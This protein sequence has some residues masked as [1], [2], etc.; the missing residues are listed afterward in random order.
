MPHCEIYISDKPFNFDVSKY[1]PLPRAAGLFI[2]GTD[3]DIGKTLVAG[4]IARSLRRGG[5]TVEVYKPAASGCRHAR[6]GLISSDA[7]FLAACADSRRTLTE[8]TPIRYASPVA[9]NVAAELEGRP[10]DLDAIFD[11]YRKLTES[12]N[13][14]IVEGVGGLLCPISDNFWVIHLARLMRLPVIIVARAGLGTINHTLLTLHAARCVKL[15]VAGVVIN[16]YPLAAA[17]QDASISTNHLQ[18]AKRGNIEI[19][20]RVPD[21]AENSVE[22]IKIGANTQFA[23]DQVD[24]LKIAHD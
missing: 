15:K 17:E 21:E 4:A 12:G 14:I 11:G 18:I 22:K 24:W 23:I 20:C 13:S 1:P 9:P 7:E 16:R 5:K 10:V 2:T 19:L 6:E 3:T 8:I